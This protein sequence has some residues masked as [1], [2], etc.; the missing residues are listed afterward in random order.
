V[1]VAIRF[2]SVVRINEHKVSALQGVLDARK[3]LLP[4]LSGFQTVDALRAKPYSP[5]VFFLLNAPAEIRQ[6]AEQIAVHW[7]GL[8][9]WHPD[10]I[11]PLDIQTM[12]EERPDWRFEA[13]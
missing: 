11:F 3:P 4:G 5:R 9:T 1:A 6:R 8:I 13:R 12:T 7:K 10:K 2:K